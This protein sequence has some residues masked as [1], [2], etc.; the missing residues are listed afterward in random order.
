ML[1]SDQECW[2]QTSSN[3]P[4]INNLKAKTLLEVNQSS[5]QND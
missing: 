5:Y 3:T 4:N 2:I 1:I